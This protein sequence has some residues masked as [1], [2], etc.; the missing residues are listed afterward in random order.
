MITLP[1]SYTYFFNQVEKGLE[2]H[3]EN[4]DTR[5]V[6]FKIPQVFSNEIEALNQ[7]PSWIDKITGANWDRIRAERNFK[8]S[9]SD[10]TQ[11]A[12]APLSPEQK[13]DWTVY[14][15]ALRDVPSSASSPEEVVWP[16]AP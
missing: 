9:Q 13:Q 1:D 5:E 16:T 8:L 6:F 15:Q 12:D 3:L 11:L 10:W 2:L 14:R 7:L 4:A